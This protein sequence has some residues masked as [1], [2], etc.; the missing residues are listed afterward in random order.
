MQRIISKTLHD[1]MTPSAEGQRLIE[2]QAIT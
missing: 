2:L 1:A